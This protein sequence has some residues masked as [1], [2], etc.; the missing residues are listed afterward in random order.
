VKFEEYIPYGRQGRRAKIIRTQINSGPDKYQFLDDMLN[1]NR[2]YDLVDM[3]FELEPVRVKK[4]P[5]LYYSEFFK[6]T[7]LT[8]VTFRTEKEA[9]DFLGFTPTL[10]FIRLV[11]E[12]PE[13]IE[14]E[15]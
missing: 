15:E 8:G 9:R 5:A 11:K 13:L 2:A 4:Y 12:I 6:A 7:K 3:D 14:E 10:K 1:N